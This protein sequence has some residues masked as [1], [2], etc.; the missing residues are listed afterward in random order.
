MTKESYCYWLARNLG[1]QIGKM[2]FAG[3]RHN[4]LSLHNITADGRIV[5]YDS[6]EENQTDFQKDRDDALL[7]LDKLVSRDPKFYEQNIDMITKTFLAN[8]HTHFHL[9]RNQVAA[10]QA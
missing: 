5:D 3:F 10:G 2:H 8:Y 9:R 4:Y 1:E 6:V 7:T